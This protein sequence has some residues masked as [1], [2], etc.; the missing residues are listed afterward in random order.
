MSSG[1]PPWNGGP[2][3]IASVSSLNPA[4]TLVIFIYW[5]CERQGSIFL[6]L[7]SKSSSGNYAKLRTMA[8][9]NNRNHPMGSLYYCLFASHIFACC[10]LHTSRL[11]WITLST[12]HQPRG[13]NNIL[14]FCNELQL[15]HVLFVKVAPGTMGA[16]SWGTR[17]T[18]P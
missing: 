15:S 5:A 14:S 10:S 12:Q 17:R 9:S 11:W 6:V 16:I 13:C 4:M 3:A 18:C 2:G 7:W 8:T 1:G